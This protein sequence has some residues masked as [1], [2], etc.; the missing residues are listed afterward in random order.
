MVH[1]IEEPE[2]GDI[3]HT[4]KRGFKPK[5]RRMFDEHVRKSVLKIIKARFPPL[6]SGLL[7]K[8]WSDCQRGETFEA[9][10]VKVADFL[11]AV[12]FLENEVLG[13]SNNRVK[14][15]FIA[16]VKDLI[17]YRKRYPW[18]VES[19]QLI[20]GQTQEELLS[21]IEELQAHKS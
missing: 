20:F 18:L 7:F 6:L 19:W 13:L 3:P 10:I 5:M 8:R 15:I 12:S 14:E 17:T 21:K 16:R 4:F 1:E 9:Q 2:T 11:S